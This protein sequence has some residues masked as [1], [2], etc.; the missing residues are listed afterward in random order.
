MKSSW[1]FYRKL[2]DLFGDSYY[3]LDLVGFEKNYD[4][5]SESFKNIYPNF[6][7]AYSYKTNYIPKVCQIVDQ[8]GGYAE[9]VS[10][11]EYNLAVQIGVTP[12]NILFNGPYKPKPILRTAL[13][14]GATVNL[15]SLSELG[16]V[17]EIAK[18]NPDQKI[19]VGIRC[20]FDIGTNNVSRFGIDVESKILDEVFNRLAKIKNC[21]LRGLHCHFSTTAK[22][23][24]T[25]TER[26]R[27]MLDLSDKYFGE[28]YP[29]FIDIGGG[30]FSKMPPKLREQF[31]GPVPTY[32]DY[33]GAIAQLFAEKY[34]DGAGPELILEPGMAIS[35]DIMKFVAKVLDIK[36]I[37]YRK[38]A[39]VAGSIQNLKQQTNS[40]KNLPMSVLGQH[41]NPNSKSNNDNKV[42]IVGYTCLEND[43]L[44][45]DYSGDIEVDD[46]VIFENIGAYSI[47]FKPPF[48]N[49]SP[50]IIAYDPNKESADVIK[51]QEE[52]TDI[53]ATYTF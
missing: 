19:N 9:V 18:E 7:I 15:D 20:N 44:Y 29:Q 11:M 2:E 52:Y 31:R 22:N 33:A 21:C 30:F 46:Y 27:K 17:E 53:F 28:N 4:E 36:T 45:R 35:S 49:P 41:T 12:S 5:F 8:R 37:R 48:I 16:L 23:V 32:Q 40:S 43:V 6:N 39:L 26:T 50:P 51:R 34:P 1:N 10:G 47:V 3:L 25:Y 24:E 42:D 13:L 38:V 14:S